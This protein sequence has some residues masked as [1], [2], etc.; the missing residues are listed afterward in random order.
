MV[1]AEFE[2]MR[3]HPNRKRDAGLTGGRKSRSREVELYVVSIAMVLKAM[4]F[5]EITGQQ[6]KE[7]TGSQEQILRKL[8][9]R[10]KVKKELWEL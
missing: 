4:G 10:G 5:Y 8:I 6:P 1:D 3:V 9:K 7:K 2:T